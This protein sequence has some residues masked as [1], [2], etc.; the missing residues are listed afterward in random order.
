[1]AEPVWDRLSDELREAFAWAQA[2]ELGDDLGTRS[3]LIGM[4]RAR[5]G[6]SEPDQILRAF[7]IPA[8]ELYEALQGTTPSWPI[9]P[10]V[11]S[12][13]LDVEASELT[14]NVLQALDEAD[15]RCPPGTPLAPPHLLAALLTMR[16][17]TAYRGLAR[18]LGRRGV[19]IEAVAAVHRDHLAS[20]DGRTLE[21]ALRQQLRGADGAADD[22]APSRDALPSS[23]LVEARGPLALSADGTTLAV[24]ARGGAVLVGGVHD[25]PVSWEAPSVPGGPRALALSH[26]GELLTAAYPDGSLLAVTTRDS[27]AKPLVIVDAGRDVWAA[28]T[29]SHDGR[30]AG[31]TIDGQVTEWGLDPALKLTAFEVGS[32]PVLALAYA[33]ADTSLTTLDSAGELLG[34]HPVGR[35]GYAARRLGEVDLRGA[36]RPPEAA[37]SPN[38]RFLV[39]SLPGGPLRAWEVGEGALGRQLD[40]GIASD[41]AVAVSDEGL[42]ALTIGR[43]VHLVEL[44]SSER[45]AGAE[46]APPR[47]AEARVEWLSDAHAREDLLGRRA[48]SDALARRL[49]RMTSAA[50]G[51]SFLVHLDGPWGAGKSSILHFLRDGLADRWLLV[52]FDAWRQSRVGPPWWAL[53]TSLRKALRRELGFAKGAWLRMRE[54]GARLRRDHAVAPFAAL[55][56]A[57]LLA[58]LLLGP[59]ASELRTAAIVIVAVLGAF[60]LLLGYGRG[61]AAFLMW[62]SATGARRYEQWH[63]DPMEGLADHFS[64][65]VERAPKP[66]LFLVDDLDRCDERHVVDLL[67]SIQTL[68][69]RDAVGETPPAAPCFIVAADGRWIRRAY[70]RTHDGFEQAVGEPGRP[71]GYLFL[72]KLFQLSVDVPAIGA[73]GQASYLRELLAP[74]EDGASPE[75]SPVAAR[76]IADSTSQREILAAVQEAR[77][78][79]RAAVAA[80]AVEKLS[81][82]RVAEETEHE[83]QKFASA[84]ERNPRSMKRFVNAYSMA[85]STSLLEGRDVDPE[86]LALWTIVRLR[87]PELA[88]HLRARPER[89]GA[90]RDGPAGDED[91][92]LHVLAGAPELQRVLGFGVG[93][94]SDAIRRLTGTAAD[95]ALATGAR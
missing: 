31:A 34:W 14:P 73:A 32:G 90:F 74:G 42:A 21:G 38:G 47:P 36:R 95:D 11:E 50:P 92:A 43:D 49:D 25:P 78:Q 39:A 80:A 40:P 7:G 8:A 52:D 94:S 54:I 83:L 58:W 6:D 19:R 91:G 69:R 41:G 76:R 45:G 55:V 64:W 3:V 9:D 46:L 29:L 4:M 15:E 13:G 35:A 1:V 60:A 85:L 81:E 5:G 86:Q 30:L 87:W 44:A 33:L 37:L 27:L 22:A 18:V 82:P 61:A 2:I 89:L 57:G 59:S 28:L 10:Q 93:L 66:V 53:L 65:L 51:D 48:L 71:L 84:L 77:P 79:E 17:S 88:D 16:R 26:D 62:D 63:R 24:C 12:P 68:V 67:D 23:V 70:E 20:P 72:D 56:L 75:P